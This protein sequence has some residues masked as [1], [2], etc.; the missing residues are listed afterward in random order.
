MQLQTVTI[1][2]IVIIIITVVLLEELT[3]RTFIITIKIRI[4][5]VKAASKTAKPKRKAGVI[6]AFGTKARHKELL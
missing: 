1:M 4:A 5:A 3:M 6:I 2:I